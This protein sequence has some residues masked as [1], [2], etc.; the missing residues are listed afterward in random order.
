MRLQRSIFAAFGPNILGGVFFNRL[1]FQGYEGEN[2][3][4][5]LISLFFSVSAKVKK[6]AHGHF[7]FPHTDLVSVAATRNESAQPERIVPR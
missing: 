5:P 4:Y 2:E 7:C 6:H 1:C 3:A